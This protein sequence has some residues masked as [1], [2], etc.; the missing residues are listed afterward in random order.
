MKVLVTYSQDFM[1]EILDDEYISFVT[2]D[3]DIN[4]IYDALYSDP[5]VFFVDVEKLGEEE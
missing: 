1:G 5:H 2:S 4:I 3:D